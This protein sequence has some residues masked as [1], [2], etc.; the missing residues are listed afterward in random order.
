[1]DGS[2]GAVLPLT[3]R[4]YRRMLL[5]QHYISFVLEPCCALNP[6][7]FRLLKSG[8]F[9]PEKKKGILD[10]AVLWSF[11]NMAATLQEEIANHMGT[12]VDA[13][14]ES[15]QTIENFTYFF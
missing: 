5:L 14:F 11:V 7:D 8:H 3:E 1:M 15:L 6:K 13:I 10:G 12:S 4:L 9:R 2:L